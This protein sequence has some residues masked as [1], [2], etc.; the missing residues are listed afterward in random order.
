MTNQEL[1]IAKY[2]KDA[3][4]LAASALNALD[5][6]VGSFAKKEINRDAFESA[7]NAVVVGFNS[8]SNSE[9]TSYMDVEFSGAYGES[10]SIYVYYE[11]TENMD[12]EEI[13]GTTSRVRLSRHPQTA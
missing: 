3:T 5:G 8:F 10:E 6:A 9:I 1:M 11:V 13:I 4:D 12:G 7:V 2:K